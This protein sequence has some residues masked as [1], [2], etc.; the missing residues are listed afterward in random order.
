MKMKEIEKLKRRISAQEKLI[1]KNAWRRDFDISKA[2][3]DLAAL[4]TQL[5]ALQEPEKL[6]QSR[7]QKRIEE[8]EQS[9]EAWS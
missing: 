6:A 3:K 1:D 8:S 9:L 2:Y 7:E 4:E 5:T